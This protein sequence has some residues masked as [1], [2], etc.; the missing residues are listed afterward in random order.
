MEL[1]LG[2]KPMPKATNKDVLSSIYDE[3]P[4]E[5]KASSYYK[6]V[7][8]EDWGWM[9]FI[10]Y[11]DDRYRETL[12]RIPPGHPKREYPK[13]KNMIEY[14][15]NHWGR[16]IFKAMIDYVFD[17]LAYYP[18]WDNPSIGLVCGAHYYS[19]LIANEVQKG[20]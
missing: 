7:E 1:K 6:E 17:N 20:L 13:L 14:S 5:I 15:I 18:K 11:W 10:Q 12:E 16:E 3:K 19:N 4:K 9:Q 2:D 8:L